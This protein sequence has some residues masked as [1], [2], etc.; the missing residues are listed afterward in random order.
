MNF[1]IGIVIFV[2]G[3][4]YVLGYEILLIIDKVIWVSLELR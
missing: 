1:Y 2:L 3:Y 4:M